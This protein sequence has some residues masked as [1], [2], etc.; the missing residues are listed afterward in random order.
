[1]AFATGLRKKT[2]DA[3]FLAQGLSDGRF[4]KENLRDLVEKKREMFLLQYALGVKK[5]E[6]T[7][8]EEIAQVRTFGACIDL[9]RCCRPKNKSFWKMRKHWKKMLPSLMHF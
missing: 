5:D 9:I 6:I 8:L 3:R 7:K 1:V 4:G 2:A